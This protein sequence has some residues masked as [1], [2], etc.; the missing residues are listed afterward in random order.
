M[1][2]RGPQVIRAARDLFDQWASNHHFTMYDDVAPVLRAMVER[3]MTIGV[4]SNSHRSLD[5]FRE[6]FALHGLIHAAVGS[7]EHGWLKPHRSIFDEA[8]RRAG[9]RAHESLMVGDSL[10]A[11]VQGALAAGMQAVLLRRSGEI[12]ADLPDG[13]RVIT[14]LHDLLPLL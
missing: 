1:G 2:G 5:A 6:H 3:G 7:S 14:T 13:A 12:P 8:L 4:I 9:M 11:D 10:K